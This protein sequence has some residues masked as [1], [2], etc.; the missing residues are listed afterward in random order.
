MKIEKLIEYLQALQ[1][2]GGEYVFIE[3]KDIIWA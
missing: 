3:E 1:A 2:S